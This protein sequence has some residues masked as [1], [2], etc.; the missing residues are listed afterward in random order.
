MKK[1]ALN[2]D[3]RKSITHSWGRF[4]SIMLLIALGSFALTGLSI[5]GPD[6]RATG[7]NYFQ[8]Y[9]TADITITSDYGIDQ[10]EIKQIEKA[11]KLKEVEYIYLKD[12][13]VKETNKSFRLFS[14]PQNVSKYELESGRLP[15]KDNEIAIDVKNKENY[16]I[17]D[18]I[19]FTENET[20][21]L[22]KHTFKITGFI[23]SPEIL[24]SLNRGETTVGTG[25]LDFYGVI[26]PSVFNSKVYMMA[27]LTFEDTNKLDPYGEEYNKK[28]TIHKKQLE[29]LLKDSKETRFNLIKTEYNSGI[30]D[31]KKTLDDAKEQLSSSKNLL[32]QAQIQINNS[33]NLIKTN[34][35]KLNSNGQTLNTAQ[36]NL[37]AQKSE[38][39]SKKNELNDFSQKLENASSQIKQNEHTLSSFKDTLDIKESQISTKDTELN[40]QTQ[41]LETKKEELKNAKQELETKKLTLENQ[42]IDYENTI[43]TLKEEITKIE[44]ILKDPN[45]SEEE[46][47]NYTNKLN[48]LKTNL[49]NIENEYNTFIEN[50]YNIELPKINEKLNN[51]TKKEIELDKLQKALE[52]SKIELTQAKKELNIQKQTYETSYKKLEKAKYE[53][54]KNKQ[55]YNNSLIQIQKADNRISN[56]QKE[57]NQKNIEYKNGLEQLKKAKKTLK[58]KETE[59]YEKLNQYNNALPEAT[60][61]INEGE[62][63]LKQTLIEFENLESPVYEVYNRREVPGGEG[64]DIY[65][66]VSYIIDSLAKVFPL[67]MYFVAALVTLTTMTRFASEERINIGTLK[68]LGYQDKDIVKK[69]VIYGF[70][71]ASLGTLIGVTTGHILLPYIVYNAYGNNFTI[72]TIEIHFYLKETILAFILSMLCS[73]IPAY[74]SVKSTLKEKTADLLL[75][76]APTASSKI[77][78]EKIKPLWNRLNFTK[79]VTARNIFR[80]K[81]RMFM[82]IFGVAGASAILFTGFSV[83]YSISI[84]NDKQFKEI[85]KYDAIVAL[86][87]N[88]QNSEKEKINKLLN[89]EDIKDKKSVYYETVY[90]EIGEK[91]DKQEINL[92]VPKEEDNFQN[93]IDLHT[94]KG[95]KSITLDDGIVISERLATSANLK[96]G[97]TFTFEDSKG[98]THKVKISGICEMY[99]GHFIFM[100]K[101]VYQK[102]YNENFK[103]NAYMLILNDG[104]MENTQEISAKFMKLSG[105]KGIVQNTSMY[106]LVNAIVKSLNK[107]MVV[108]I[109]LASLLTVVI[110]FNLTNINVA[111]R[112]RELSTIKVLGFRDKEVTMYIYKETI[113]LSQIG[114]IVGWLFG[115]F[116]HIYI[117]NVVPPDEVMFDP[118]IWIGAYIISFVVIN[119]VTLAL[120][121]YVNKKLIDVDMIEALKSVD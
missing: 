61:K 51:I 13:T 4:I 40:N 87:S 49:T 94:R 30:K 75:P 3:I 25:T 79:K 93:Y 44:E 56:F 41:E 47:Q 20:T 109:V 18:T 35:N 62:K 89:N 107:I 76:K 99:A 52:K 102:I 33:K 21:T 19:T 66:T 38:L 23:K 53:Y 14:K 10:T 63:Q 70:I 96:K 111:E 105:V 55:I 74:I 54:E 12:V 110:L 118:S 7:T 67:F 103:S 1:K 26:N 46:W 28:V 115:I 88:I 65:E 120:K 92:I 15:E 42:K 69:F 60:S 68:A 6:M 112:I 27:K 83:Q 64:Y 59:Y 90:K 78:L 31:A 117:L 36:R 43:Q 119:V 16:K 9:N 104:S 57:L 50:T 95:K 91:K 80:Y 45:L 101:E 8:K 71:S 2:K 48:E 34:E 85:I 17:G 84:I 106:N 37:N 98:N 29:N 58:A 86:E 24:S 100:N 32:D 77:L 97:D 39:N 72:P 73:V 108:L 114:I 116:L 82:T 121:F 81:K 113:I 22:K 5:T 11:G